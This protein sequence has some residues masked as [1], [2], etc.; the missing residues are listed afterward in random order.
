MGSLD[1][2]HSRSKF[3]FNKTAAGKKREQDRNKEELKQQIKSTKSMGGVAGPKG[4][5]P[6]ELEVA[7]EL[8]GSQHKID[9]N[10][11]KKI[12]AHDFKLLRSKAKKV[13]ENHKEKFYVLSDVYGTGLIKVDEHAEPDEDGIVDWYVVEF[14]H[15]QEKIFVEDLELMAAQYEALNKGE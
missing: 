2:L 8:K 15:G 3:S 5:L 12:D 6:E 4:K 9:A 13:E 10:K 1:Q 7:E 11:N 14:D